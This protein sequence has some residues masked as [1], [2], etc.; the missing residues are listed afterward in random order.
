MDEIRAMIEKSHQIAIERI[1]Y[2][3]HI[4]FD[5]FDAHKIL[6]AEV[7]FDGSGDSGGIDSVILNAPKNVKQKTLDEL[8]NTLIEGCKIYKGRS[9]SQSQG[10]VEMVGND[11]VSLK[12]LIESIS[13]DA[14]MSKHEGWENNGGA[15]GTLY[16]D[17][18]TRSVNLE[19]NAR[20]IECFEYE[21]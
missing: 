13:Y 14:L 1:N 8:Q 7:T 21:F 4:L 17:S 16:F 2:N 19:H 12:D 10:W 6:G 11:P 18:K 20:N 15:Y 3:K 9:F 5:F